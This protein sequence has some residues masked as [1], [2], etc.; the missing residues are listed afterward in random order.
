MFGAN[1]I[2]LCRIIEEEL[3]LYERELR[4]GE[5][6]LKLEIDEMLPEEAVCLFCCSLSVSTLFTRALALIALLD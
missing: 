6:R 2:E 3:Q 4:T 1:G 5:E